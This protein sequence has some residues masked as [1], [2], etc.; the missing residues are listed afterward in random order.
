MLH[1]LQRGVLLREAGDGGMS[2][3]H[4]LLLWRLASICC[5]V[6]DGPS[7]LWKGTK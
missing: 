7:R 2:A 5:G 6:P 4:G 3:M 1:D